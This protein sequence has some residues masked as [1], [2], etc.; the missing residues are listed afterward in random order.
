MK[1]KD[2]KK[3]IR[4]IASALLVGVY[5][6]DFKQLFGLDIYAWKPI[7]SSHDNGEHR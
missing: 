7:F 3:R 4:W 6:M 2:K 1:T 5:N